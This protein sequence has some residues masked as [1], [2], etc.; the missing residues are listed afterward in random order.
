MRVACPALRVAESQRGCAG[1]GGTKSASRSSSSNGKSSAT[2]LASGRVEFYLRKQH[3]CWGGDSSRSDHS[4]VNQ[5]ERR[6]TPNGCYQRLAT[7]LP[8][9][10]PGLIASSLQRFVLAA[11]VRLSIFLDAGRKAERLFDHP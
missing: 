7:R 2:P 1:I 3:C 5:N 4:P 9:M 11:Q 6:H 10:P 8:S